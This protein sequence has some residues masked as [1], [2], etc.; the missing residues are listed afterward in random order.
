MFKWV[1]EHTEIIA[2]GGA[3]FWGTWKG[4]IYVRRKIYMPCKTFVNKILYELNNNGGK[5]IKDLVE[6][7]NDTVLRLAA[8]SDAMMAISDQCIFK[9]DEAGMCT[10]A[11]DSLCELYGATVEEMMGFGW[12]NFLLHSERE[13][14]EKNWLRAVKSDN[15]VSFDYTVVNGRTREK[16]PCMYKAAIKR[17]ADGEVIGILGVVNKK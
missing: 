2:S 5:S 11:N 10:F 16:V 7:T 8:S 4:F 6:K 9:C 17:D 14:S 13:Q 15:V 3:A 1:I 12:M